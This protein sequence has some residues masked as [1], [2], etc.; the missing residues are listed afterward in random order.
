MTPD[1]FTT[2]VL[3]I[4]GLVATAAIPWA[5]VVE[6]RMARMETLLDNGMKDKLIRVENLCDELDNRTARLE[7]KLEV[8]VT[9]RERRIGEDDH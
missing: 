4:M 2:V 3:S 1:L 5:Y 7:S 9:M 6:R 8:Y